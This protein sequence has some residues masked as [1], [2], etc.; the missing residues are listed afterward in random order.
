MKK[1]ALILLL[2]LVFAFKPQPFSE[3]TRPAKG[4]AVVYFVR[5]SKI[6]GALA[7]F[8]YYDK[9]KF[10]GRFSGPNFIRYECEP[11]EHLFWARSN[12]NNFL[13]A[14]LQADKIYLIEAVVTDGVRL[15][16]VKIKE[17]PKRFARV[18]KQINNTDGITTTPEEAAKE[19]E[20][21]KS[22]I[23]EAKK[24]YDEKVAKGRP[25]ERLE[26]DMFYEKK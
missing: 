16:A 26:K 3:I 15:K 19:T 23:E 24:E 1:F 20:R 4:K 5:T 6:I 8:S 18:E 21:L 11:G 22:V 25:I 14:N 12:Y 17:D 10:I 2:P 9:D 13:V 7:S